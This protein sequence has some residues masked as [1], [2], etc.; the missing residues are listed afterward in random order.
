ME[1]NGLIYNSNAK[2]VTRNPKH[3]TR[4]GSFYVTNQ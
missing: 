3:V 1:V 2:L 4:N